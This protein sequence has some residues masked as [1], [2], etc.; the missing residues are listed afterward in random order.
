MMPGLDPI[1]MRPCERVDILATC[2][3]RKGKEL[4]PRAGQKAPGIARL[5]LRLSVQQIVDT[6]P[7]W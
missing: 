3:K 5:G 7:F 1:E 2:S 6:T 4:F